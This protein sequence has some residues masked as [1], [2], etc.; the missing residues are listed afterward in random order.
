MYGL[1]KGEEWDQPFLFPE[2][3]DDFIHEESPMRVI[4]EKIG[5]WL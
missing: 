1:Y 5:K 2:K 3:F 4:D